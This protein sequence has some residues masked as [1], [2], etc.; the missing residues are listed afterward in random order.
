M[1]T[2]KTGSESALKSKFKTTSEA[3]NRAIEDRGRSQSRPG[4][5]KWSPG[6]S[7]DNGGRF[8]SQ[9]LNPDPDHHVSKMQD[10][11]LH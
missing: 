4:G 9:E 11:D 5:S 3:Q 6:G 8:I 10:P 2:G 1:D 7:I